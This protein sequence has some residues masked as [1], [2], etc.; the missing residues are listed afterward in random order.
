MAADVDDQ[1]LPGLLGRQT[2]SQFLHLNPRHHAILLVL[3]VL[4]DAVNR[5]H[6]ESDDYHSFH[7]LPG[8]VKAAQESRQKIARKI[9]NQKISQ[10]NRARAPAKSRRRNCQKR[11]FMLPAS[12]AAMVLTPGINFAITSVI[13]PR[14]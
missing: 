4:H 11:I 1:H 8:R 5:I 12:G 6:H 13:L 10:A 7:R 3:A 2:R 14:L 9:S